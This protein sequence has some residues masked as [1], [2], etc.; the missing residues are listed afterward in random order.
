[1]QFTKLVALLTLCTSTTVLAAPSNTETILFQAV[2]NVAAVQGNTGVNGDTRIYFQSLDNT[3]S[4]GIVQYPPLSQPHTS[5]F[6]TLVPA[7]EVLAGTP[8][9]AVTVN[10]TALQ[11]IHVFF[12]SPANVLSEYYWTNARGFRGGP[13][14][15]ECLTAQGFVA[16]S[17]KLL[18]AMGDPV[19]AAIRLG[20]VSAGAPNGLSEA[21]FTAATGWTVGQL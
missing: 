1:M 16:S 2:G 8:I 3:I 18:Y 12:L 15:S 10:G 20:F 4:Q 17:T 13:S 19:T 5:S 7:N 21:E 11:E 6:I 9:A 14:C